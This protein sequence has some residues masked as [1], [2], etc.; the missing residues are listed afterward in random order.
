[1]AMAATLPHSLAEMRGPEGR[2]GGGAAP[3]LL[4]SL[5][6]LWGGHLLS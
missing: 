1:M 2:M 4:K 5:D 6:F 3:Y